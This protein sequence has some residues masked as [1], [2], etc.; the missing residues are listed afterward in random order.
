M[1]GRHVVHGTLGSGENCK[2]MPVTWDVLN[3]SEVLYFYLAQN[4]GDAF[5]RDQGGNR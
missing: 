2:E 3:E 5:F 1:T 4:Y